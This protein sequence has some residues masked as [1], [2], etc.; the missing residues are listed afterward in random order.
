MFVSNFKFVNISKQQYT[1]QQ[2]QFKGLFNFSKTPKQD[3]F[4]KS[5][6]IELVKPKEYVP[7]EN[8]EDFSKRPGKVS[9][10]EYKEIKQN[11]PEIIDQAHKKSKLIQDEDGILTDPK[12]FAEFSV[13]LKDYYDKQHGT[14][15]YNI[16]AIGRS[17]AIIAETLKNL[18]AEVYFFP[19]SDLSHLSY[20]P[21]RRK[22]IE[23]KYKNL[24][25]AISYLEENHFRNDHNKKTLLLDYSHTGHTLLSM[26]D[27]FVELYGFS[28]EKLLT[29]SLIDD[30]KKSFEKEY[31]AN[32]TLQD[33]I[34]DISEDLYFSTTQYIAN[35]PQNSIFEDEQI[36]FENFSTPDGRI[37]E[38]CILHEL[39]KMGK[40]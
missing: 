37:F 36:D 9:L 10:E 30:I 27:L 39:D 35:V 33:G 26:V 6:N 23:N 2:I 15:K 17:P 21:T 20:M 13:S 11:H 22:K 3:C 7:I 24:G 34:T 28:Y 12:T 40:L 8:L 38:L 14:G 5:K 31:K 16:V 18:G 25:R 29:S 1:K 4:I 32:K 19:I